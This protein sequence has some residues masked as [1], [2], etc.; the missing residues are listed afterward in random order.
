MLQIYNTL[1]HQLETFEPMDGKNVKMYVCGPTVY[2][3]A[4]IGHGRVYVAFDVVYRY[5]KYK[6]FHV[7]YARNLTD[8]DDKII[9]RAAQEGI[10]FEEHAQMYTD[11]FHQDMKT[12]GLKSPDIEPKATESVPDIISMVQALI[13]KGFAYEVNGDV[14]FRVRKF[15][16]YGQLSKKNIEDLLVGARVSAS[17]IKEDALDFALWKASKEGEPFWE[18]PWGKGRPGWHIECSAMIK[19]HFGDT[20]DIHAGGRDLIFPHHENEIAQSFCANEKPFVKYWM[21][22]GF[23]TMSSEKMSKSLGNTINLKKLFTIAH[24]EALKLYLLS[25]QYRSPIDFNDQDLQACAKGLDKMV[26]SIHALEN[27]QDAP[28]ESVAKD[29]K[30]RFDEAMD[31]DFNTSKA[32]GVLY[33]MLRE[34]NKAGQKKETLSLA[35][36]FK[37]TLLQN[38]NL[39]GL[40]QQTAKDYFASIP[41]MDQMDV[42]KIEALIVERSSARRQKDF[43]QADQI[44]DNLSALGVIV[45]DSPEG[46]TWRKK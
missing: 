21:H 11:S 39:L 16:A 30:Q 26:R 18:S 22:N 4:H 38:A 25:S 6:G 15:K 41:G 29:F 24:P 40:L 9:H 3:H 5:L 31:E 28:D 36:G 7:T 10:S 32:I 20:I 43:A 27:V 1:T 35:M 17:D 42:E 46:S 12:L 8:I 23:V 13:E 33:E 37:K 44:R 2:D 19:K 14:Y 34:M 45:E